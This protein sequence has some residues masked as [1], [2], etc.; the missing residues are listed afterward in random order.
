MIMK[1]AI[2]AFLGFLMFTASSQAAVYD[3]NETAA[4]KAERLAWYREAKFGMFIHWGVYSSLGG[5]YQGEGFKMSLKEHIMCQMKIPR[6]EYRAVAEGWN[7]VGFNADE[8]IGKAKQAGMRY[9]IITSKH[10]DGFALFDSDVTDHNMVDATAFKRDVIGELSSAAEKQDI[11]FG[12]YYSQAWDWWHP[13]GQKNEGCWDE[14]HK[15]S[16]EE[17]IRTIAEPQVRC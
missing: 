10:H 3:L 12:V 1:R 11:T 6:E 2:P 15:G 7:P 14:G 13:G 4:E 5:E 16:G 8:W 17:Y 9:F